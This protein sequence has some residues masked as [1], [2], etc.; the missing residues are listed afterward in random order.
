MKKSAYIRFVLSFLLVFSMLSP[1]SVLA[2]GDGKKF[3]KEG[4]KAEIAEDWDRAAEQFALAI[5]DNPKNP[6]YRL[7]YVRALFNASQMYIRKGNNLAKEND[8]EGAY[9][10]YRKAYAYDP[11]NELAKAEMQKMARLYKE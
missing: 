9:N 6:E 4:M 8:Y 10:A 11:T 5:T 2:L 3:F 1:L 7:H